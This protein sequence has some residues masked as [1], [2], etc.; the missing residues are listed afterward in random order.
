M[1][2]VNWDQGVMPDPFTFKVRAAQVVKA[3]QPKNASQPVKRAAA[4]K[5][6][7]PEPTGKKVLVPVKGTGKVHVG[8]VPIVVGGKPPKSGVTL[9]SGR[10]KMR[11]FG[12]RRLQP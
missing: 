8:N 7:L 4:K 6:A 2:L 5:A 11:A 1:A 12:L 3:G 9:A 10:G